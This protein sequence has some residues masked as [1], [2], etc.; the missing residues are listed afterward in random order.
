MSAELTPLGELQ[1]AMGDVFA[2]CLTSDEV[3]TML[4]RRGI[5]GRRENMFCCPVANLLNDA[6]PGY[7][8]TVYDDSI[9]ICD[10]TELFGSIRLP[11]FVETFVTRFDEGEWP[12][13]V[14]T[15]PETDEETDE[16]E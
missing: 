7:V 3:A 1:V 11:S 6:L 2:D 12:Q 13:L 8:I 10:D 15:D 14:A 16:E 9:N 5:T 4:M